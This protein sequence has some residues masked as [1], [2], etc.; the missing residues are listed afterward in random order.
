MATELKRDTAASGRVEEILGADARALLDYTSQTIPKDQLQ[1][2]GPDFVD[3][4]WALSDRNPRVLRSLQTLF[5]TGRLAGTGYLSILPVDQGIE[6]SAGSSFAPNP[7]YFDPENI[8]RLAVEGGCNQRRATRR[9]QFAD[10]GA[11]RPRAADRLRSRR[12]GEGP[13]GLRHHAGAAGRRLRRLD[14]R[15]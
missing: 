12:V 9:D 8:V 15:P 13:R 10:T 3:R 14:G 1:L 2:P 7:I 4:V 6:H 5:D 11:A